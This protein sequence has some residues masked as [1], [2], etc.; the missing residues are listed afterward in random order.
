MEGWGGV[1]KG[2]VGGTKGGLEQL[3]GILSITE[4]NLSIFIKLLI[5]L[6]KC[7]HFAISDNSISPSLLLSKDSI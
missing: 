5:Y 3:I 2:E 1:H 4:S 6:K 7:A